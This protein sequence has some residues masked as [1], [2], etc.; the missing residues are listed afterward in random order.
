LLYTYIGK[1]TLQTQET[2]DPKCV[3]EVCGHFGPGSEV[4]RDTLVLGLK[5]PM[6]FSGR[7]ESFLGH[8]R[9]KTLDHKYHRAR[10]SVALY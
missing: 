3:S 9:P 6:F 5:C 2:S 1:W 4:S 10:G 8:F 7:N